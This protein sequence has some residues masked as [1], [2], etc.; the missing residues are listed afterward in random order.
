MKELIQN[1]LN[2]IGNKSYDFADKM[3]DGK[4]N[5]FPDNVDKIA[6]KIVIPSLAGIFASI[7]FKALKK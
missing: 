4:Q 3:P 5:N 6:K 1:F 7:I 2:K